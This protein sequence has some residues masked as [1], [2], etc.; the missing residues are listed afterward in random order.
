MTVEAKGTMAGAAMKLP[1]LQRYIHRHDFSYNDCDVIHNVDVGL[2]SD[3]H[4]AVASTYGGGC[5][6]YRAV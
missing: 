5:P 2:G 6:F 3:Y 4:G 1:E